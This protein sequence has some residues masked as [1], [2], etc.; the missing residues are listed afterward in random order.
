MLRKLA[1]C[2]ALGLLG[3]MW[4][5]AQ[6]A[7]PT[8]PT[9][10]PTEPAPAQATPPSPQ[11]VLDGVERLLDLAREASRTGQQAQMTPLLDEADRALQRIL[12][13][14]PRNVRAQ[15]LD[16]EMATLRGDQNAARL[17]FK[18]V[19]T[20]DPHNFRA[21]LGLG[22]FYLASH[23]WRQAESYLSTAEG[24]APPDKR[25][26][27]LRL[28]AFCFGNRGERAAA[29][30]YAERAVAANPG[31]FDSLQVLVQTLMGAEMFER[32]VEA[33]RA[34]VTAAENERQ[35]QPADRQVLGQLIQAKDTH[36]RALVALH[37]TLYRRNARNEPTDE[38]LPGNSAQ[39]ALVLSQIAA[40]SE[41]L[42]KLRWELS[43]HD[44]LTYI[45][46]AAEYEPDNTG[47]LMDF[48]GL[49]L[50]TNQVDRAIATYQAVL[51]VE[52]P[53]DLDA[54]QAERNKQLARERLEQLGAPLTPPPTSQPVAAPADVTP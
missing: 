40:L 43:Y 33:A 34:M 42:A 26:E 25:A 48:A 46:K 5:L 49:L 16:G 44:T 32:A 20:V 31:D 52:R 54:G 53:T 17:A 6:G 9:A 4:A 38:L 23:L 1:V 22:R 30:E 37:N 3:S 36:V 12:Q 28:L 13:T 39:A 2:M 35:Q 21:N 18:K 7:P 29:V 24:V 41:D 45:E 14:D 47:Y 27:V 19:L 8:P 50:A 11:E 15:V 51:A 10:P